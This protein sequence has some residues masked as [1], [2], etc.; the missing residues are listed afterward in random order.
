MRGCAALAVCC[1]AAFSVSCGSN[2]VAPT[3]N[4]AG[5]WT[6]TYQNTECYEFGNIVT[7]HLCSLAVV[8]E[9]D[10]SMTLT[11]NG[12]NVSA[13]FTLGLLQFQATH[14]TIGSGGSLL[15]SATSP[16]PFGAKD[17][18]FQAT[19]NLR[20]ENNALTGTISQ[21]WDA[22]SGGSITMSGV[23]ARATRGS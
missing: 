1:L 11:Q 12:S 2:P 6:G 7:L 4:Y 15:L 10:Y 18:T 16:G 13:T 8:T 17:G 5:V 9:N 20:L 14:G 21:T 22:G 19:W 3:A 23:I